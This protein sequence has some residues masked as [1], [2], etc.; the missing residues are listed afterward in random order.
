[1]TPPPPNM[2]IAMSWMILHVRNT[3]NLRQKCHYYQ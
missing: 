1:M 3:D 2:K